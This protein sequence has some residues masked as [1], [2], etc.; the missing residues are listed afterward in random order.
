MIVDD[1]HRLADAVARLLETRGF[2]VMAFSSPHEALAAVRAGPHDFDAV[3]TDWTMPEMRGQD[4][5]AALREVCPGMPIIVSSGALVDAQAR[6]RLGVGEVLLKPWRLE[7]AVEALRR[8]EHQLHLA[9]EP[10]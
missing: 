9:D 2:D 5:I 8:L 6:A 10:H 1:D 3:L 4:F 7:E